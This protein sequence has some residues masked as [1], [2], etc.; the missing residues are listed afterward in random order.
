MQ[1]ELVGGDVQREEG[2]DCK[3]GEDG[4]R[5]GAEGGDGRHGCGENHG[6][7]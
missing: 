3:A 6:V 1:A 7:E 4:G 5:L 2:E